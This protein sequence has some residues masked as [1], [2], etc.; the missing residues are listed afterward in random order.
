MFKKSLM[1]TL[2]MVVVVGLGMNAY[3]ALAAPGTAA[4]KLTTSDTAN[5]LFMYEEEKLARDVYNSLYTLWGQPTFQNITTSE[6]AHMDAIQTLL[7]RY[8]IA[9]PGNTP[10]VFNDTTLQTL[11]TD[12]TATGR[13]SLADALKVGAKIEEV[14][15]LDLQT[16][17][18]QTTAADIIQ[19]YNNLMN[20]SYNHLRNYVSVLNRMA[21]IVYQPQLLAADLY[22]TII[23]G[24][25]GKGY[26]QAGRIGTIT[27]MHGTC[28]G[29][30]T[31]TRTS[32]V[33]R[34][35]RGGR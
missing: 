3:P 17:V 32:G 18:A 2:V 35:Y 27:T 8:G 29:T 23:S 22:Q 33:S 19:V 34:G 28:T 11:Y 24:S 7:V 30:C 14:D 26:G 5:L 4:Q 31:S 12:L 20:G 15:I 9:V 13:L 1:L 25:N 6:Q 16:R 10:G 21:G